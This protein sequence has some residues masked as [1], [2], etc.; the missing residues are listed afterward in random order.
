M[1]EKLA[2]YITEGSKVDIKRNGSIRKTQIKIYHSQLHSILSEDK[3]E[4]TMPMEQN[5][6]VMLLTG[7]E[8]DLSFYSYNGV[9]HCR[10]KVVGRGKRDN[11][12]LLQMELTT[13][14]HKDQRRE[15]YRFNCALEM[16]FRVL[17]EEEVKTFED[18]DFLDDPV[19]EDKPMKRG[20]I[21][22]ISGG[23]L[24]F[25]ADHT[26]KEGSTILCRY[27]LEPGDAAKE[28]E[29]LG[30]ILGSKPSQ[31]REDIFEHRVQFVNI[32]DEA[33]EE[34]IRFIFETERKIRRK[35]N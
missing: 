15:F 3:I 35:I 25:A 2:K 1:E 24:R 34:I 11:K 13:D 22:D 27:K 33:R 31:N 30:K 9:Y 16:K 17:S 29:V 18:S 23:G 10:A 32:D 4:I 8:Y 6:I 5:K 7:V 14:L 19:I 20:I 12:F 21:V 26:I 28:Y